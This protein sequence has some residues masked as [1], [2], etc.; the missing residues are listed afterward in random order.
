M[1]RRDEMR[2]LNYQQFHEVIKKDQ[3]VLV[4][5]Y[6]SWCGPCKMMAPIIEELAVQLE[7]QVTVVKVNV[8][9]E[10]QLAMEYRV[11]SIPTLILFKNG[12][13]VEV[14]IGYRPKDAVLRMVKQRS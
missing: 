7:D 4:D 1:I 9:E 12:S 2:E 8:D 11:S 10:H 14:A 5:F 13:P 6:A 3:L